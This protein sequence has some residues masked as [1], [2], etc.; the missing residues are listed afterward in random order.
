MK[1]AGD[2]YMGK[3]ILEVLEL[4]TEFVSVQSR[5]RHTEILDGNCACLAAIQILP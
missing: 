1:L 5:V 3:R 4:R 2:N